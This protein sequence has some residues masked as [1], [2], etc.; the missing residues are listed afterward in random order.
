[1]ILLQISLLTTQLLD[2][3]GNPKITV[4]VS[5]KIQNNAFARF[6]FNYDVKGDRSLIIRGGT[7]IFNRTCSFVWLTNMPTNAGVLQNTIE[8]GSYAAVSPWIGQVRFHPEDIYYYVKTLFIIHQAD[9][10]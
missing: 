3:N 6:G 5:T 2:I 10:K 7:G 4:Q 8:P 1:M 9:S